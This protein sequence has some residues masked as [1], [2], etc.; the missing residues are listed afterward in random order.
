MLARDAAVVPRDEAPEAIGSDLL[1]DL[2][3]LALWSG[4]RLNE[5]RDRGGEKDECDDED[6]CR[7]GLH[8]DLDDSLDDEGAGDDHDPCTDQ[9][10]DAD[11]IVPE[12]GEILPVQEVDDQ[13]KADR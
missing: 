6:E 3:A 12:R 4:D 7:H 8:L 11:R 13:E 5:N 1:D 9:R 10:G 2:L